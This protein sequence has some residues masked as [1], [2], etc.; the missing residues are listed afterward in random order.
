MMVAGSPAAQAIRARRPSLNEPITVEAI[1]SASRVL[2]QPPTPVS[3]TRCPLTHEQRDTRVDSANLDGAPAQRCYGIRDEFAGSYDRRLRARLVPMSAATIHLEPID[4][5]RVTIVTDNV[6]DVSL[7]STDVAHRVRLPTEVRL[8]TPL[9]VAEH[10]FSALLEVRRGDRRSQVL[11]DTGVSARGILYNLDALQ[12]RALDMQA[13]VIS[14]G[15]FDHTMGLLGLVDGSA[16]ARSPGRSPGRLFGTQDQ[17]HPVARSATCRRR[18]VLT[19]DVTTSRHSRKVGPSMLIEGMLLVSGEVAR[20]SGFEP[21]LPTQWSLRDGHWEHD[22]L[23]HDDQCAIVN[24][25]DRGLVVVTGCGH[26]GVVNIVRHAQALTGVAT[27]H[28]VV[29]GFHLNG[30]CSKRSSRRRSRRCVR[31]THATCCQATARGS[32]PQRSWPRPCP[33][34]TPKQR[35]HDVHALTVALIEIACSSLL[36]RQ[37]SGWAVR[38]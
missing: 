3:V 32:P 9:P 5:L 38:L 16:N 24:L 33:K 1:R 11:F 13:I 21:G 35:R 15:H 25:K 2:P 23:V 27:I 14:H 26:A 18:F 34:P 8:D 28:A 29:G 36:F 12:I 20:T 4:E 22:P 37:W 30:L 31:L 6:V 7:A 19:S 10:G 17:S